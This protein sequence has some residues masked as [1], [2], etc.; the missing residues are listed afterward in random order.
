MYSRH[1]RHRAFRECAIANCKP[2]Q[3]EVDRLQKLLQEQ[4]VVCGEIS[5]PME[6]RIC[7]QIRASL[8]LQ[9]A[10]A[11]DALRNCQAGLPAPG[12]QRAQGRIS[13]LRV[14]DT[15]GYGP[16]NDHLD[17]EVIFRL[18]T[19]PNR[20]FGFALRDDASRPAHEGMLMLLRDALAHD[21]D[22]ATDY[23]QVQEQGE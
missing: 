20:A 2:F 10:R 1:T 13:F 12:V 18:D 21:F 17:S 16:P 9:L 14:H 8:A 11:R 23:Q 22:V 6:S 5:D 15:G 7:R 4:D 3:D 19:Q